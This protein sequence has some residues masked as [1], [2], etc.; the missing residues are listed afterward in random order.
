MSRLDEAQ[1]RL[2]DAI[3]RFETANAGSVTRVGTVG[4][5]QIVQLREECRRLNS[6]LTSMREENDQ[7][8]KLS[9]EAASRLDATIDQIDALLQE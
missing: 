9:R 2:Q 1:R 4:D 6:A 7:L 3:T 8:R 5:G